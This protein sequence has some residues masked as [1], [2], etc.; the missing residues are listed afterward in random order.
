MK[1]KLS[2]QIISMQVC[3]ACSLKIT[4]VFDPNIEKKDYQF[5]DFRDAISAKV[6][7][8]SLDASDGITKL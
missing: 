4:C 3:T 1:T 6:I 5:F 7:N 2:L 8:E